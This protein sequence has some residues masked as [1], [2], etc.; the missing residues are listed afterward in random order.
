MNLSPIATE[1][2]R[3]ELKIISSMDEWDLWSL[4]VSGTLPC[5]SSSDRLGSVANDD[6]R[7]LFLFVLDAKGIVL[8][9][10][11]PNI[12]ET[13]HTCPEP[14]VLGATS[15]LQRSHACFCQGQGMIV[16]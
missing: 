4:L 3:Y 1:F 13:Q 2:Q 8:F 16:E 12:V 10:G 7:I 9:V 5:I 15:L 11:L 14:Q 6:Q